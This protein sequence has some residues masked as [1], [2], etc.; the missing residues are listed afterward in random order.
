MVVH[1]NHPERLREL[2][3]AWMARH[4]LG[5]LE[6][7]VV[8]VQS[9]GIAQWLKLALAADEAQG[10]VGIAAA[11]QTKL[12][13]Q[14]LWEAYRHVLGR[15]AVPATSA[16]DKS[17][18]VWR[19]MRLLPALLGEPEFVPLQRF[20]VKDPDCRK[21][22]QLAL[23]VADLFDQY[24][25]Y[26]ADW[27]AD[28]AE[29]RD[30]VTGGKSGRENLGSRLGPHAVPD[31]LLWQRRLWRELL[32]DVGPEGAASSRAEVHRRF[33]EKCQAAGDE[34]PP[35]LPRR[36]T[37][38]GVS[39]LPQQSLEVL[40]ALAR[41]TQVLL[42]VHNPCEHDWSHIVADQHLLRASRTRRKRRD[43]GAIKEIAPEQLH[44][45]SQP[46]LAAWG[47]QG[48]DFIRLL[49]AH[50]ERESYEPRFTAAGLRIDHFEAN[51]RDTLLR[52]LQ[53]DIR[54]LRPLAETRA[55]WPDVDAASDRSLAF[56]IT[57][58][59][60]REVEVLHDQLLAAFADDPTLR[61]RDVIVMV[62]DIATYAAHVQAVFG[63]VDR[64]DARFIPFNVADQA[65]RQH[66]PLLGALEALLNLPRLRLSVSEVLDLLEVPALRARFGIAE[67]DLPL[68]HRWVA[69]ARIR[70]GLHAEHRQ[71]LDLPGGLEQNSWAFGLKR[72]LLGYAVGAGESW[73]GIAPLDEIGGL[74]AALLGPLVRLVD[75]L[76][77]YWRALDEAAAP[78]LWVGRLQ[79]LLDDFFV[80]DDGSEDGLTML[81]L[82][83]ALKEWQEACAAAE[84]T[85]TLPL[86]VVR[87][88]WLGRMESTGLNQP[89]FAG[90]VT[91]AS[92]MP[93]RAIPF[94]WV[95]LLG[96]NDG[97]YP[98]SRV[99]MDFDLM[100]QDD[101]PGDRSRREDDRYL[102]LEALLSAREHLHVSWVGRSIH[103]N[104]DRPPSVLVAQ[105]RDHIAAGWR[106]EGAS[107]PAKAGVALLDALTVVHRLQPFHPAYFDG[108]NERLFS[109]AREWRAA[110]TAV[111]PAEAGIQALAP[112]QRETP[113]TLRLL[114][115]FAKDPVKSF[116][117]QRL[118][119]YFSTDDPVG[120]D[121]EPFA[122]DPLENW[123]LQDELI[124]AQKAA[125][126]AGAARE[127]VLAAQLERIALQGN[128]PVAAFAAKVRDDLA[129]PMAPLFTRYARELAN[130]P[131]AQPDEHLEFNLGD[132]L[133]LDDWLGGMRR[134][135]TG[136]RGRVV[137][138]SSGL[139]TGGKQGRWKFEKLMPHWVAHLAG[140]LGGE[141][142]TTVILSKLGHLTLPPMASE[143]V[144]RHWDTL[145]A[146]WQQGMTRALPF[147]V[148]SAA[149]WLIAA[150]PGA[151]EQKRERAGEAARKA[152]EDHDPDFMTFGERGRNP[153]LARAFPD[154]EALWNGGEFEEWAE[155]LL[156][157]V[158]AIARDASKGP[159][160]A[161]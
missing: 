73:Q 27:L 32:K 54:D 67:S 19:L 18:L 9:N 96:M 63:L 117:R 84:L 95:A 82:R 53:D 78:A 68:L 105:L 72:M 104:E 131:H 41:W 20:L 69:A 119:I 49:D 102:F 21:R 135:V 157:P 34:R 3:L 71:A 94:R 36:I 37:V 14:G 52:Q 46:L 124:Q 141:E 23:R 161:A 130:W 15:D 122:L 65:Q 17:R 29:G 115:D 143:E 99:P 22:H 92:L 145:I 116:F 156:R 149:A 8:L 151:D 5:P 1:G 70:W 123:K 103:D 98:R 40:A 137:L 150:P 87:E 79:R 28:W 128:L 56:H 30:G 11:V 25:V 139:V 47:R 129:E 88:H 144:A 58:G 24:Q 13:S 112:L 127:P 154:F 136:K 97:D 59:P 45:Q 16:F 74:D 118:N 35:G 39:S 140:Q 2:M 155:A 75:T 93:M 57:H 101:R 86:P 146:A 7:E 158:V 109:Y 132:G 113:L 142:L 121:H 55:L 77:Q 159:E 33:I 50:D 160:D 61:P 43:P 133:A 81:R 85:D 44:L 62:P 31:D 12:P 60:Q 107:D 38:F 80:A 66:D 148:Q 26:R 76:D 10:G 152:Y 125:V 64:A 134:G 147:A 4:P 120:Q 138:E 108:R 6:D 110:T 106:L 83:G 48:R 100:A 126:D 89:F 111:I 91:F 51:E 42:C 90:G 153:Y 114:A